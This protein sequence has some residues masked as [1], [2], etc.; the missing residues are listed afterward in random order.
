MRIGLFIGVLIVGCCPIFVES[1]RRGGSRGGSLVVVQGLVSGFGQ[2]KWSRLSSFFTS[3]AV[4]KIKG[5]G[6][7]A[8]GKRELNGFFGFAQAVRSELKAI[9]VRTGSDTVFC[10]LKEENLLLNMLGLGEAGYEA[11]FIFEDRK[12]C[13]LVIDPD[14]GI[15]KILTAQA[16]LFLKWLKE[17]E[18]G[19]LE[20]LLPDGRF[21]FTDDSGKRLVELIGRW[22][23][24]N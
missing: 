11:C 12:V 24:L 15:N 7:I 17:N 19:A 4:V 6:V 22:Q 23:G 8:Q 9:D 5:L 18:P 16:L 20:E 1:E 3:N 14:S 10:R 21:R 13:S 2:G